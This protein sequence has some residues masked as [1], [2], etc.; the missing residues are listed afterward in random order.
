MKNI[1]ILGSTGSI[2]TQALDV[3]TQHKEE[4]SVYALVANNSVE[5][6]AEQALAFRPKVVVIGNS[7]YEKELKR[8]LKGE[9]IEVASGSDAINEVAASIEA[10]VVLTAMV[11]FAG[12]APTISAIE[13]GRTIALANKETLVVAGDLIKE[14]CRK[15]RSV[16][17]PVD[18]EH[19]A[20]YQCLVGERLQA[21]EKIYLTASGGPFVDFPIE[22]L[23][24]V[25]PE[26]ALRHPN[27]SMGQKVTIDS[28]TMMNKGLEMIEAHHLFNVAPEQIEVVVHRQS[29]IHSMVG[30]KDGSIKAQLSHPDMRHPI[31]YALLFPNR[32]EG[33]RP[34][35]TIG[36]MAHLTFE[37]PRRDA[38]PCLSLAYEALNRGGTATCTMNAANEIA[39]ER[40]LDKQ[41]RFTDIPRIIKYTMDKAPERNATNL[42]VL[43]EADIQARSI[44]RAWHEGI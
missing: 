32:L 5:K 28:A 41:I 43:Q 10:D 9:D 3:V 37:E 38:F 7:S 8:R 12:L 19:S 14:L 18:S 30:Y 39:V 23:E 44:A 2:G 33:L 35:L 34:L 17:L 36:E 4:L 40:F 16:I 11:G 29:I 42:A 6:L 13:S 15:H 27:W 21:V 25:T 22:R 31:A 20:I 1:T 26:E 24:S